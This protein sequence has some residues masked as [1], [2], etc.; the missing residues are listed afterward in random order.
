ME[1]IWLRL[2]RQDIEEIQ[3]YYTEVAGKQVSDK[4]VTRIVKAS[5]LLAQQ[6]Y[7]GHISPLDDKG[8]IL[9]WVIPST[10]Y[11]LPYSVVGNEVRIYRVFDSRQEPVNSWKEF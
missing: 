2:A 9:E 10:N 7:I 1:I 6:P 4:I 3:S 11:I 5:R 8:L